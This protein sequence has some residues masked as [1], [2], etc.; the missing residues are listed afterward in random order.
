MSYKLIVNDWEQYIIVFFLVL[1]RITPPLVFNS[2][3]P[4]SMLPPYIKVI[5]TVIFGVII[6]SNVID[7]NLISRAVQLDGMAMAVAYLN[8]FFIGLTFWLA[9][10]V[11]YG[12]I[13]TF[14]KLLDMQV[15]FNPMGIF[16]PATRESEPILT[17]AIIIFISL[18]FFITGAHYALIEVL[19]VSIVHYP[20]LTGIGDPQLN[21]M[22][23]MFSSQLMLAFMLALPIM[24]SIFWVDLILG[25]CNRIMPQINIYFVGLPA[26]TAV[27]FLVLGVSSRH[28]SE[29]A[30]LLFNG[31]F[32]FW[33]ALY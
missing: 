24:I 22:I 16:N 5:V 4:L 15:G 6:S 8:E 12:A 14:L 7:E 32:S 23:A 25:L 11:T 28:V 9:L 10:V 1:C 29:V 20:I 31:V 26:K 19:A 33:N 27:A 2:I 13:L 17:R 21:M 30:D 3:N 18:L